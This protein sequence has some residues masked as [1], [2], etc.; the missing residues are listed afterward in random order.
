MGDILVRIVSNSHLGKLEENLE[1]IDL[2]P[3][4]ILFRELLQ[5]YASSNVTSNPLLIHE[6]PS[7]YL[8]KN[9]CLYKKYISILFK[10]ISSKF[11]LPK[12][13]LS[14]LW[15]IA[16]CKALVWT[17]LKTGSLPS[18]LFPLPSTVCCWGLVPALP[19][20]KISS[21]DNTSFSPRLAEK[22]NGWDNSWWRQLLW[23]WAVAT[24]IAL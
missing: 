18:L 15:Y 4:L 22:F 12:W 17:L 19:S 1:V 16:S 8:W 6:V 9:S 23:P 10:M 20:A 3:N 13:L 5:D 21:N 14:A 11:V 24:D 7:W 2:L